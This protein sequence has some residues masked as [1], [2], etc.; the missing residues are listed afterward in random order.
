M[1]NNSSPLNLSST[2][3]YPTSPSDFH[4]RNSIV[5]TDPVSRMPQ[6]ILITGAAGYM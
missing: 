1:P 4:N 3:W 6:N 2:F 5:Q